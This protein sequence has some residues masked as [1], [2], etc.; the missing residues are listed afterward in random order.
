MI[1]HIVQPFY[2]HISAFF[3]SFHRE[4]EKAETFFFLFTSLFPKYWTK[5]KK[6]LQITLKVPLIFLL[7]ALKKQC[8]FGATWHCKTPFLFF[9]TIG[10][11][12]IQTFL[13]GEN[14]KD[15]VV[16]IPYTFFFLVLRF[17]LVISMAFIVVV[18]PFVLKGYCCSFAFWKL[19]YFLFKRC[20]KLGVLDINPCFELTQFLFY[21]VCSSCKL[22]LGFLG[23][24]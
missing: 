10:E 23:V 11:T 4:G 9:P 18:S 19:L 12:T 16:Q 13:W 24:Y 22:N 15:S 21:E 20:I 7:H 6:S 1:Y 2:T 3:F 8:P 14:K 17:V 5:K